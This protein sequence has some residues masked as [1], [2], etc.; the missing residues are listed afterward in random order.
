MYSL[1]TLSMIQLYIFIERDW[2]TSWLYFNERLIFS[3]GLIVIGVALAIPRNILGHLFSTPWHTKHTWSSVLYSLTCE[4]YLV[5]C[6]L[7][8]DIRNKLG[9]LFSTPWHTKHTWSSVL[10]SLTYDTYLVICSLLLD[11]RYLL[12]HLFSTPC[13][14]I[15]TWSSVLYSLTYDTYLVICSL[16]LDMCCLYMHILLNSQR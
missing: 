10:Y 12:G 4:T 3:R 16:L 2:L 5:I 13:H 7:H 8:H 11:I 9:H 14:T 6:S 1:L 15:L